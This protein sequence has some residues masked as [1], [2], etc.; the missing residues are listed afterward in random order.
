MICALENP[1]LMQRAS[2]HAIPGQRLSRFCFLRHVIPGHAANES[3][4]ILDSS[5]TN[6]IQYFGQKPTVLFLVMFKFFAHS[7][8]DPAD[9]NGLRTVLLSNESQILV[10]F[11]S[12]V[13]HCLSVAEN[14]H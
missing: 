14:L 6:V 3:D 13:H 7:A 2:K 5:K 11:K 4:V 10:I 8:F 1:L 9:Q 12:F